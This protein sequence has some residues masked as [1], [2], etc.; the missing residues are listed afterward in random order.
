MD[1]SQIKG[2]G[3][4]FTKLWCFYATSRIAGSN[5]FTSIERTELVGWAKKW[6]DAKYPIHLAIHVDVLTP[7][8]VLSLGFQ[9]EKH[10][11]VSAIRHV[12][13]FNWS[14]VK[15]K[16]FIDQSLDDNSQRLTHYTKLLKDMELTENG[17]HMY[18]DLPLNQFDQAKSSVKHL[19]DKNITCLA[20]SMEQRFED[21]IDSPLFKSLAPILDVN[22]WPKNQ[23]QLSTYCDLEIKSLQDHFELLLEF[24]QCVISCVCNEWD[25]LKAFVL[26]MINGIDSVDYL[27]IWPKLLTNK[28]IQVS[29]SNVLHIIELLLI[30]PFTDAKLERMFS[31]LNHIKTDY[32]NRLGQEQ[33]EHLLRI[34]EEGLKMEEF[35]ANVFMGFWYDG[36]V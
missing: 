6:M 33:F 21:L 13:K 29:C 35:D 23:A 7:L 5:R 24:N 16:I 28:D 15:L 11:P 32:C 14:M 31:Q 4:G 17:D 2:S 36:K 9:K 22:L 10:D 8:K 12:T 34:G 26:P 25:C 1:C 30:T 19:Y 27:E 20:L 18:H 3:N